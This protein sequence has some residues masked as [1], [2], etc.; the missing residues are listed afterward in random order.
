MGIEIERKF[1][2]ADPTCIEGVRGIE[3]RQGY[4]AFGPPVSVRVR[5]M[6]G[7]AKLNIKQST[8]SI[9]RAEYEYE[10]PLRDGE[11][12]LAQSC[13]GS[14]VEKTRHYLQIGNFTWELDCF[15]GKN[16]GLII[17]EIELD[18][19][20]QAFPLPSWIGREV[21]GDPRYL[22]SSLAQHPYCD[23]EEPGAGVFADLGD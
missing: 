15:S 12:L 16:T 20:H 2:V 10:I 1:L 5:I 11:S 9:R 8:L 6:G 14:I 18:D 7:K 13:T 19:E 17:A 22:N 23:W 21:S 4:L 3:S